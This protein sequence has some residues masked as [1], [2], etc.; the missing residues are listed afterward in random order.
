MPPSCTPGTATGTDSNGGECVLRGRSRVSELK[1]L[2]MLVGKMK[3][4]GK[5]SSTRLSNDENPVL[6]IEGQ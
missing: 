1:T 2:K 3:K 6:P 4:K 5:K